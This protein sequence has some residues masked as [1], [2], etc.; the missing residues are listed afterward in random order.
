MDYGRLRETELNKLLSQFVERNKAK[1][2][3]SYNKFLKGLK[4]WQRK[5]FERAV[6]E[7]KNYYVLEFSNLGGLVMPILLQLTYTNGTVEDKYIPA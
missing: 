5:T 3:N 7:D 4:P 6:K 2:R 1:G